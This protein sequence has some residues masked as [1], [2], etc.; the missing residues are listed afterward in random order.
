MNQ[1]ETSPDIKELA[2]A[3]AAAQKL[4]KVAAKET[5]NSHF[6]SKY[7]DLGEVFAACRQA[8]Q[9][10]GIA[11]IQAPGYEN[12]IATLTTRLLHTSGQWIQATAGCRVSKDDPQGYGSATTYLRRFSLSSMLGIVADEDDDGNEASRKDANPQ[13]FQ[14]PAPT[15]NAA[16]YRPAAATKF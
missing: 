14:G 16:P 3:L 7:A 8:V 2:V 4:I 5:I 11:I 12:G 13:P 1:I 15:K 6:K 10:Y 9:E